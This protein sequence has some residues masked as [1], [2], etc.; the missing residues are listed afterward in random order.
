MA[1][2]EWSCF[3]CGST[4]RL[5]SVIHAL[6]TELFKRSLAIPDFPK[7]PHI[8]GIGLSDWSGYAD[9]LK[10]KLGYT[11]TY[12]HKEPLLDITSVDKSQHGRYD[13]I[14]SSDV[15]EH[16]S[17][18]ISNAFKNARLL[19]KPGGVMILT[20]PYV[21]GQTREHFPG[22]SQFSIENDAGVWV[23]NGR[24]Q[25]GQMKTFRDITFH[26]GPGTTVEMRL[27]G[28]DS[29]LTEFEDA[30]F[31]SI[32]IH[33]EVVEQ[34]GIYWNAYDAEK[35][36]YRPFIYGLDTPPW[37]ARA[38]SMEESQE[39]AA[40]PNEQIETTTESCSDLRMMRI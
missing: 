38:R 5:R 36:P 14:I 10:K 13:F 22:V 40:P 11:N 2:E 28:E 35:A 23:L 29:I 16:V 27:F 19:L 7:S 24:D 25:N 34:F 6:S 15:F 39:C 18:P 8:S 3:Y 26:G 37:I 20:V 17:P 31:D 12:Y 1:R 33:K 4:V 32:H 9:R 21:H 30:G